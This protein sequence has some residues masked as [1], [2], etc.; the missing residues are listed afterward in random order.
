MYTRLKDN[1]WAAHLAEMRPLSSNN[2]SIKFLLCVIA[3]FTKHSWLK[4][5]NDK[6]TKTVLNGFTEMV[7]KSKRKPNNI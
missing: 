7:N 5:L 1:I 4:T 2:Q 3:V 6:N